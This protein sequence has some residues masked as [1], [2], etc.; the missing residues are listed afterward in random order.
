VEMDY[1]EKM[2]LQFK[3]KDMIAEEEMK[4]FLEQ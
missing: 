4:K 3:L 2:K 1:T